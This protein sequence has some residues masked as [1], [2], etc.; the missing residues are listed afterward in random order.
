VQF[1]EDLP[2]YQLNLP[3]LFGYTIEAKEILPVASIYVEGYM[4]SYHILYRPRLENLQFHMLF[5]F[6]KYLAP[7]NSV[8][9]ELP[10][11]LRKIR[12]KLR[13]DFISVCV[14]VCA[15]VRAC[16]CRILFGQ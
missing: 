14:F 4:T 6:T 1:G 5:Y 11:F 16:V 8:P 13:D 10:S 2:L 15:C 3:L 7:C 9:F 12:V